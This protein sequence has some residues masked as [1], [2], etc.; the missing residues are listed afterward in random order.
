MN[1]FDIYPSASLK[2]HPLINR[3]GVLVVDDSKVH[4][5][6]LVTMLKALGVTSVYEAA[7][8]IEALDMLRS[9]IL[10]PAIIIS[11]LEMPDMNGV[12]LIQ[13]LADE[14]YQIAIIIASGSDGKLLDT[15]GDMVTACN[16]PM[17]GAFPK[18][19][20]ANLLFR[21][22]QNFRPTVQPSIPYPQKIEVSLDDLRDAIQDKRIV[23]HYQPK[24]SLK[25][26]RAVGF[27][28]LARMLDNDGKLI[29]PA[30]FINLAE[31]N[32]LIG[33]L[34][35]CLLESVL[36]DMNEWRDVDLAPKVSINIAITLFEDRNFINQI[37]S[38]VDNARI[39]ASK[40]MLEITESAMMKDQA[41]TLV[42]I[43]RLRL[44]GFGL[45]ID[46][47]GTGFSSMQQLTR[48]AFNELKL[49]QSFVR[50]ASERKYHRT[51]VHS[52][53]EM[54]QKLG[55]TTVAEGVD[56]IE[57]LEL[58]KELGCDEIQGYLFSRPMSAHD[59]VPWV[60]ENKERISTLCKECR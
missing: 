37:I 14:Q 20:D 47:Y 5:T 21:G 24:V 52:A 46:D 9:A 28:A 56:R 13:A 41:A 4:R 11:D 58:L 12:E 34:T 8:G 59:V 26:S 31:K 48:I 40:I 2:L 44:K 1:I 3:R 30:S 6:I 39:P 22:L 19:L 53:I 10:L 36:A 55:M 18:P 23:P 29:Q 33:E 51:I 42:G 54:A 32:N 50:G 49:D 16:I 15:L 17:L 45:S 57:E 60:K 25:E 35:L 27:E 7:S 43:G 38:Q